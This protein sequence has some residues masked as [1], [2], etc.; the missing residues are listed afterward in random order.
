MHLQVTEVQ[1]QSGISLEGCKHAFCMSG[2]GVACFLFLMLMLVMHVV[3]I[4]GVG[5]CML[6][7]CGVGVSAVCCLMRRQ[8]RAVLWA[9]Y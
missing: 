2:A 3:C 7:V 6:S 9:Q 1:M 8:G 4:P 5:V